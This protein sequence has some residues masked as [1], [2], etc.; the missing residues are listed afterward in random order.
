MNNNP[1]ATASPDRMLNSNDEV[2]QA[3]LEEWGPV[4]ARRLGTTED[5]P[6]VVEKLLDDM[7]KFDPYS[8]NW[9]LL[10]SSRLCR[11]I[12]AGAPFNELEACVNQIAEEQAAAESK[13]QSRRASTRKTHPLNQLISEFV[14]QNPTLSWKQLLGLLTDA[15]TQGDVVVSVD[16]KNEGYVYYQTPSGIQRRKI[17]GLESRLS[18]VKKELGIEV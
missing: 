10:R 6:R 2:I 17:S 4:V 8:M 7:T 13:R 3:V 18:K 11:M 15:A 12:G 16:D 9:E 14:L 1:S 5:D